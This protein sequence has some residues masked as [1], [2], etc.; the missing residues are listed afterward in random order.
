MGWDG[1][2]NVLVDGDEGACAG[3]RESDKHCRD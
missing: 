2:A 3:K 1:L